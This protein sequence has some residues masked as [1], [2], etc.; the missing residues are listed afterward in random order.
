MTGGLATQVRRDLAVGWRGR[1]EAL[2]VLGFFLIVITLFPLA[3]GPDA[4]QLRPVAVP[5]IWIA[6]M[7]ACLSGFTRIFSEDVRCGWVD[8]VALSPLPLALYALAKAGVHWMLTALPMLIVAPLL[9]MTL[10]LDAGAMAPLLLALT[11][12]TMAL[13][14]LGVIGAALC[15]GARGGG[16]L[17]AVLVLPLALPV[18]IFGV[19]ASSPEDGTLVTPHLMLL[20]AVL[21][22]LLALAP[23][24]AATA[25]AEAEAETGT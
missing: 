16:G 11:L 6:A 21:L 14:L 13:T 9:A 12:G 22:V 17:M 24:V 23:L 18:L 15:E 4:A 5:V 19:L 20:G 2:V 3:I 25:L 8:Q 7:L 1:G 10:Y